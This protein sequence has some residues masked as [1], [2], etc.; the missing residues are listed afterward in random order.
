MRFILCTWL[1]EISSCSCFT[2]L[3]G[4]AWVLL[5]KIKSHLCT[6]R[7]APDG[8]DHVQDGHD[9]VE[10]EDTLQSNRVVANPAY[11]DVAQSGQ[12][13]PVVEGGNLGKHITQLNDAHYRLRHLASAVRG[14]LYAASRNLKL[15]ISLSTELMLVCASSCAQQM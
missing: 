6:H 14:S 10:A 12:V 5:N 1:G 9:H 13:I 3:P 4:P 15:I 7:S 11:A 8:H 2:V